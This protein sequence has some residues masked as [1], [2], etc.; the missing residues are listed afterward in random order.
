MLA[1]AR[2]FIEARNGGPTNSAL[3]YNFDKDRA[4]KLSTETS[5]DHEIQSPASIDG[6]IYVRL[7]NRPSYW[8][9]SLM[10]AA[11]AL[12]ATG[13]VLATVA[14]LNSVSASKKFVRGATECPGMTP[15]QKAA[16][17]AEKR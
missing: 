3:M 13:G 5:R 9:V 11:L 6:E 2:R 16:A 12:S 7:A 17:L 14:Q 1:Q 10:M 15:A 4:M 8:R